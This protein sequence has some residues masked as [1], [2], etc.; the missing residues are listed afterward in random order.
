MP[1]AAAGSAATVAATRVAPATATP[2][3]TTYAVIRTVVIGGNPDGVAVN[4]ADDTVYVTSYPRFLFVINGRTGVLDDTVI[5][6]DLPRGV[7]VNQADDTVYVA[8]SVS[9]GVSVVNGR[10]GSVEDTIA[11]DS[12]PYAVAVVQAD[13]T[14]YVTNNDSNSVSVINGRTDSV[15]DTIA[16]GIQPYGIA[17]DQADDTVY[18]ANNGGGSVSVI[19]GRTGSVDD[20]IVVGVEPFGVAVDQA[21]DSVY[22]T[23]F[24]SSSV[25]VINGRTDSV[26]DTIAVGILPWGIA[27]N[28]ADDSVYVTDVVSNSVSVMSGRTGSVDDTIAVGAQPYGVAVDQAD[29]LIYVTNSASGSVSVIARVSPSMPDP[30]GWADDSLTV[31]LGVLGVPTD[32]VVD[33]S[34]IA[35]VS[36]DDSVGTGLTRIPG[37]NQWR[38]SVPEGTGTRS[39]KV[40]LS[41]GLM[42]SAGNFTYG[43]APGPTPPGPVSYPPSAPVDVTAVAGD[44]AAVVSWGVPADPGSFPVTNYQVTSTPGSV[45]CLVS[46]PARSCEV[47]GLTNG[48]SFTFEVRA[49]NG[50]GWGAWSTRS[51]AVSPRAPAS[52]NIL[53]SGTRGQV[54]GRTGILVDGAATG[55]GRG[56]ILKPWVRFPGQTSYAEGTARIL[57]DSAGEFTW[58]R[59][60][61]KKTYVL[62][63]TE[64][65]SVS[66]N[67]V[68]IAAG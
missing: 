20:S 16:V 49:L 61:A 27:V 63:R 7:A 12:P 9:E 60:T 17:V 28:E 22:V 14:V 45:G 18:V 48:T 4:D 33:D 1:S 41:G 59:S 38:V 8:N 13:D 62:I 19:N 58:R 10:T 37:T 54:R 32:Y 68:V 25:S 2:P 5:V 35:S 23:N 65:G 52:P 64:D 26:E 46:A 11:V 43:T 66:S 15:D 39:V 53:I 56:A 51:S 47:S 24:M 21:D 55:M 31:S 29:G 36:F 40:S 44:A 34:T 50:A 3:A 42:A 67:R 57:V 30:Y 6:G